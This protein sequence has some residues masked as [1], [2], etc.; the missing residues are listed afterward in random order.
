MTGAGPSGSEKG[1]GGTTVIGYADVSFIKTLLE[2]P[3]IDSG[4]NVHKYVWSGPDKIPVLVLS[5]GGTPLASTAGNAGVKMN[6]TFSVFVYPHEHPFNNI[7]ITF[8]TGNEQMRGAAA[9][10]NNST[11]AGNAKPIVNGYK[12]PGK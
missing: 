2:T 4:R 3:I 7:P 9:G 1:A 11:S 5:E 12:I 8:T 10:L 6:P